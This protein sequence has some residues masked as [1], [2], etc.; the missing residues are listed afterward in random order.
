[1]LYARFCTA[2]T[3]E[4]DPFFEILNAILMCHIDVSTTFDQLDSFVTNC[5]LC[6]DGNRNSSSE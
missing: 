5:C 4:L 2:H 1:M 6:S 3:I